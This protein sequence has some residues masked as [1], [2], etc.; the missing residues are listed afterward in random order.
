MRKEI[1]ATVA[2]SGLVLGVAGC[3][4]SQSQTEGY[5]ALGE[6]IEAPK[7]T[8]V[9]DTSKIVKSPPLAKEHVEKKIKIPP[10]QV[11]KL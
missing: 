7:K 11:P 9:V 3:A 6:P 8:P 4:S 2:I 5:G 10:K 1:L